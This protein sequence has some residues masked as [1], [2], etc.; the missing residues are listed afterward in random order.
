M[1][2]GLSITLTQDQI[3][4]DIATPPAAACASDSNGNTALSAPVT[5]SL[6]AGTSATLRTL[7]RHSDGDESEE[8]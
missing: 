5:V 8:G 4:T 2:N 6:A 1:T 7:L 3:Q